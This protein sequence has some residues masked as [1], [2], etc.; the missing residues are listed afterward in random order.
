MWWKNCSLVLLPPVLY[1]LE[2]RAPLCSGVAGS[3]GDSL[4]RGE[5]RSKEESCELCSL[6]CCPALAQH[7]PVMR[8]A[9]PWVVLER[10]YLYGISTSDAENEFD[11]WTQSSFELTGLPL[12]GLFAS[13]MYLALGFQ[14]GDYKSCLCSCHW[15]YGRPW[16]AATVVFNV[17]WRNHWVMSQEMLMS[18]S[19]SVA[20]SLYGLKKISVLRLFLNGLTKNFFPISLEYYLL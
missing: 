15:S 7:L 14:I 3:E 2:G 9:G 1:S 5:L 8:V 4:V 19:A 10:F 12:W 20:G 13:G 6:T 11:L 16:W 17:A 18:N